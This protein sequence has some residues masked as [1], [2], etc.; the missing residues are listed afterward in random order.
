M[1]D[2]IFERIIS[3]K[4]VVS[5]SI[6]K[7]C[8]RFINVIKNI[9]NYTFVLSKKIRYQFDLKREYNKLGEYLSTLDSN[10]YDLSNDKHFI[11]QMNK[12][13]YRKKLLSYHYS[14]NEN[15]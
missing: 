9:N 13:V 10:K 12:I 1:F 8:L 7:H 15:A 2:P 3:Y 4:T 5:S 11:D 14:I 6:Q